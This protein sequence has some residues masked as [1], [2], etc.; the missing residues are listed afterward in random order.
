MKQEKINNIWLL[1]GALV[2]SFFVA[3]YIFMIAKESLFK[4]ASM[5]Y[6][7]IMWP[8]SLNITDL[9]IAIMANSLSWTIY[10]VTPVL[11]AGMPFAFFIFGVIYLTYCI[12]RRNQ[13]ALITAI[14]LIT[15][16]M[17]GKFATFAL[18]L[19]AS[20]IYGHI[21]STKFVFDYCERFF[22]PVKKTQN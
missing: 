17:Y 1:L 12:Y 5:P 3:D 10:A 19:I 14:F 21:A 16:I 11:A 6:P 9:L 22:V 8:E 13:Y 18:T 7:Q 20:G 4:V 2:L 15:M